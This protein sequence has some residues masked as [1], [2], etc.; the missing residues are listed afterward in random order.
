MSV[1]SNFLGTFD[2]IEA[3]WAAYP[4]GGEEGD[5][6]YI[7]TTT[8]H[9]NKYDLI[10]DAEDY[11][12]TLVEETQKFEGEVDIY[13][14]LHVGGNVVING[15][16]QVKGRI[17]GV[18]IC[19][20]DNTGGGSGGSGD[21]EGGDN[22]GGSGGS[23]GV[24]IPII[25]SSDTVTPAS[26]ANVYSALAS[27]LKFLDK[28]NG[29][30]VT[31][32]VDFV[33][34][35]IGAIKSKTFTS[36]VAGSGFQL[37]VN[38]DGNSTLEVDNLIVRKDAI[39]NSL[40]INQISF[41]SGET[42][43]SNGGAEL[44]SVT[45]IDDYYRCYYDTKGGQ[46]NA[47]IVV[48]DLVRCQRFD[49]EYK[50]S[51]YY[52][53]KCV[54]VGEGYFDLDNTVYDGSDI[55]EAGD[56]AVQFG[57]TTEAARQSAII[58]N[59]RNGGS[60]EV[61]S[62][63]NGF[64]LTD[65]NFVGLGTDADTQEAF[66]Y[67]L[68]K[69]YFGDRDGKAYIAYEQREGEKEKKLYINA[70]IEV[71][72]TGLTNFE[73][74]KDTNV[75]APIEYQSIN[76]EYLDAVAQNATIEDD[77]LRYGYGY[78]YGDSDIP[79]RY[80]LH[81]TDYKK[82]ISNILSYLANGQSVPVKN[83]KEG[84]WDLEFGYPMGYSDLHDL[85]EKFYN[86]REA[87][88][89][90]VAGAKKRETFY[91]SDDPSTSWTTFESKSQHVGDLWYNT[92]TQET[93]RWA[94]K[95]SSTYEWVDEQASK[96]LFDKID[97]KR[98]IF[99]SQPTQEDYYD[100]GD[101]WVNATYGNY[102]NEILRCKTAKKSGEGFSISHWTPASSYSSLIETIGEQVDGK[103]ETFCQS[104][105]PSDSWTTP[106][107]KEQHTGDLWYD[108]NTSTIKS[109]NGA[110]WVVS[111]AEIP[112]DVFDQIDGKAQIFTK[113]PTPPYN[114]GDLWVNATYGDYTDEIL[115]CTTTKAAGGEF[116]INDWIPAS[117]YP[118]LLKT[119]GEQV[120]GKAETFY[121]ATPPSNSWALDTYSKHV[122]DLWYD[123]TTQII[124]SWNGNG[125]VDQVT[126]IPQSVFDKID[127]K[128]QIFTSQPQN[129][130]AYSV[131]DLWVNA[132]YGSYVNEILYCKTPKGYGEG[133]SITHWIP[134]NGYS[135]LIAA[136]GE[137]VD[138]KAE[139]FYEGSNPAIDWTTD[140]LK[141]QHKGDLWYT[142]G[143]SYTW[144]GSDW[145]E[146]NVPESV[147]DQ[148]DG[149]A[150]IFVEKPSAYH[151]NDMW[152]LEQ[153]FKS[154]ANDIEF[155][156]GRV[157][158]AI[159]NMVDYFKWSDWALKLT[160]TDDTT[161][162]E[163]KEL[164]EQYFKQ[165][166][167]YAEG[168]TQGLQNQLD[169]KVES[170]FEAYDPALT[171]EPASLWTTDELKEAHLNDT[172]TNT[173][174]GRSWR[175][176]FE[177][178][179]YKWVEIEDTQATEA[180]ALASKA[181]AAADK[182]ITVYVGENQPD[183]PYRVGDLWSRG[184]SFQLLVCVNSRAEGSYQA[185]DWK[186]ADDSH[187][188][189]DKIKNDLNTLIGEV[190]T[191]VDGKAETWY[192]PN[193]PA[194]D[195]TT[196][197]LKNQ[198]KGDLWYNTSTQ[199][200]QRWNGTS[201]E[202]VQVSKDVFDQIDGK[203]QIFVSEPKA[204]YHVGDLWIIAST[205]TNIPDGCKVGDVATCTTRNDDGS[206]SVNHWVKS[207]NYANISDIEY[208]K[209]ALPSTDT[210]IIDGGLVLSSILGVKNGNNVVA[211]LM[212]AS[213]LLSQELPFF[214]AGIQ[215]VTNIAARSMFTVDRDGSLLIQDAENTDDQSRRAVKITSG[216]LRYMVGSET[217]MI[218]TPEEYSA[219]GDD[220][221]SFGA[222]M[223]SSNIS[224]TSV[225][226][227]DATWKP[228]AMR[229]TESTIITIAKVRLSHAYTS[230]KFQK[231]SGVSFVTYSQPSGQDRVDYTFEPRIVVV[232][233]STRTEV[234]LT[235]SQV[236]SSSNTVTLNSLSTGYSE[237]PKNSEVIFEIVVT[238]TPT[239]GYQ[240]GTENLLGGISISFG[241]GAKMVFSGAEADTEL[242]NV[243]FG[244]GFFF[245]KTN[246]QY[247]GLLIDS[248]NGVHFEVRN[249][250]SGLRVSPDGL[251]K[252]D[253]NG[254]T[255][256]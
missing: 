141:N 233:G 252:W 162:E 169:G 173:K 51:K 62:G 194:L 145:V 12:E 18:D 107:L 118:E 158:F 215:D 70:E 39:F 79:Y 35:I 123:T 50:E 127:G 147:Y 115:R 110:E 91:Q 165:A 52:W 142:N 228:T 139:T 185:S 120:D 19:D 130:D 61:Y 151:K 134:A 205:D 200:T 192:Q 255:D 227:L 219:A 137:Q 125:W 8:Y 93:K 155:V 76:R 101:L 106:E 254:W 209:T 208:L 34:P 188:Y 88:L 178:D 175:W 240:E 244:N 199:V 243:L 128:A 201:W 225:I 172:F 90:L 154:E 203:A 143:R 15:D 216:E 146:S 236:S 82:C 174:T 198:H 58:I 75:I 67:G 44:T 186:A 13:R 206:F 234:K 187:Q 32:E 60:V 161:A 190:R 196:D 23:G 97:G 36:G 81:Y 73:E 46:V 229:P 217:K 238:A 40:V 27:K 176:L 29:G 168:L 20:C 124:K 4:S 148:I 183:V 249:G 68:G 197:A 184:E 133:F 56:N 6:L 135:S 239:S 72:S 43:Y 9:W 2:S 54:G 221:T 202:E 251:Q 57:N 149:K 150:Q 14:E 45:K 80:Y 138:G 223:P 211:A 16:L 10:W 11:T 30:S 66:L 222:F 59:P 160:Y 152:V 248:T 47:C 7:G 100:I 105:N 226:L 144:D 116:S 121:Q 83:N 24:T 245:G 153:D 5:Y 117:N 189:A 220:S 159:S 31:G 114:V 37:G 113:Q 132:T 140:A 126:K 21:S 64:N 95:G 181:L 122:G 3:V 104:A 195:W 210:T 119:I 98:Q 170:F 218:Q 103:A 167:E 177:S 49:T 38:N 237:Y 108:T 109:W 111:E 86:Y 87:L 92:T 22:S 69:L 25:V 78:G 166:K 94:T 156:R 112:Q 212:N 48:N 191:Q 207:I 247:A 102:V 99:T 71:G 41:T 164:A 214:A 253:G 230:L 213:R 77:M 242:D 96:D 204:P 163:A 129:K 63:I 232:Q 182:K 231:N 74:W 89:R 179:E 241:A 250:G 180:L 171:N 42:V 157:V 53:R 84:A 17:K 256:L 26:D 85:R 65:K 136:I 131:G 246:A 193:N 33:K 224:D 235:S 55:P 1:G 28:V